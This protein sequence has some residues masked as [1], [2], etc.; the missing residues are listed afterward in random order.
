MSFDSVFKPLIILRWL[1]L[2]VP[3]EIA[4]WVVELDTAGYTTISLAL[5]A[6]DFHS[7]DDI[8]DLAFDSE[9]GT[10]QESIHSLFTRFAYFD[11]LLCMLKRT[12]LLNIT[13]ASDKRMVYIMTLKTYAKQTIFNL[14][15]QHLAGNRPGI[16]IICNC[17]QPN[18]CNPRIARVLLLWILDVP[19]EPSLL[20]VHT[21]G[22]V[23]YPVA[24][25]TTFWSHGIEF[26][27]NHGGPSWNRN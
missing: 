18:D 3:R 4:Q 15:A 10:R 20:C 21:M 9:R 22:W 25:K 19:V 16:R 6:W 27:I 11:V 1:Q 7:L 12:S 23:P 5:A 2:G 17:L 13:F 26:S 8:K 24:L 14:S